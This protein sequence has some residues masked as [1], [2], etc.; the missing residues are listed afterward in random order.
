MIIVDVVTIHLVK[1]LHL[2]DWT[3]LVLVSHERVLAHCSIG[4]PL[5]GHVR[6]L[7]NFHHQNL[8]RHHND[9]DD[10]LGGGLQTEESADCQQ[11]HMARLEFGVRPNRTSVLPCLGLE[12]H[13]LC[14]GYHRRSSAQSLIVA[15]HDRIHFCRDEEIDVAVSHEGER[16]HR[17]HGIACASFVEMVR[18]D[19]ID[20]LVTED[21][22]PSLLQ[23]QPACLSPPEKTQP[24]PLRCLR[25]DALFVLPER[26][27]GL[28]ILDFDSA[29]LGLDVLHSLPVV[30]ETLGVEFPRTNGSPSVA[31]ARGRSLRASSAVLAG[32]DVG[33]LT[34]QI[35]QKIVQFH[36]LGQG[37]FLPTWIRDVVLYLYHVAPIF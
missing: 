14:P 23:V 20:E 35:A 1:N 12:E 27:L 9:L 26:Q 13:L 36:A 15:L 16:L 24:L 10:A 28:C 2:R 22:Q 19:R 32:L 21:Y 11:P 17:V 4:D 30:Y 18:P 6:H 3:K 37:Q 33:L 5:V 8:P 7:H 31:R 29:N 25:R 34:G